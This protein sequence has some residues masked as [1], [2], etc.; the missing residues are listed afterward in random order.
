MKQLALLF[1]ISAVL[2]GCVITPSER[3]RPPPAR[4]DHW[5]RGRDGVPD[6]YDRDRDGDGI[7]DRYDRAPN[8]PN[9]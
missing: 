9:R 8:N 5:D 2:S 4:H 1:A 3:N 6:R 7:P